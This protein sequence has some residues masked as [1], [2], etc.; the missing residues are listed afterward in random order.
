MTIEYL[1]QLVRKQSR[2][3]M[4]AL[5]LTIFFVILGV[6]IPIWFLIRTFSLPTPS[7]PQTVPLSVVTIAVT[8][9]VWHAVRVLWTLQLAWGMRAGQ[10][11][12]LVLCL[13]AGKE[14]ASGLTSEKAA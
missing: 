5:Y 3:A 14:N 12:D 13:H 4:R 6:V 11:E 1:E 10:L 7:W 2:K 8:G 9:F